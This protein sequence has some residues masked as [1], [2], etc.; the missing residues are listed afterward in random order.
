MHLTSAQ[1]VMLSP[2][3]YTHA[4][5]H[6]KEWGRELRLPYIQC[7]SSDHRGGVRADA[8]GTSLSFAGIE[9]PIV[10][11]HRSWNANLLLR[12]SPGRPCPGLI[13]NR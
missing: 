1:L 3:I 7:V 12:A 2:L 6:G 4:Q 8:R 9:M 11:L 10:D 5:V 13:S